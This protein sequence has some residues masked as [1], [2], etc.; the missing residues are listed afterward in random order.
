MT[1]IHY[2]Q[3]DNLVSK[4]KEVGALI[5]KDLIQNNGRVSYFANVL[6]YKVCDPEAWEYKRNE[7]YHYAEV[8][9]WKRNMVNWESRIEQAKYFPLHVI[10]ENTV[11]WESEKDVNEDPLEYM[12]KALPE[13]I[14]RYEAYVNNHFHNGGFFKNKEC[15]TKEGEKVYAVVP[16]VKSTLIGDAKNGFKRVTLPFV[17]E[18]NNSKFVYIYIEEKNINPHGEYISLSKEKAND[19]DS[20]EQLDSKKYMRV[21]ITSP[22]IEVYENGNEDASAPHKDKKPLHYSISSF[23]FAMRVNLARTVYSCERRNV[24]TI[25]TESLSNNSPEIDRNNEIEDNEVE[26]NL[27]TISHEEEVNTDIDDDLPFC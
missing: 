11:S 2:L 26:D 5:E 19:S 7:L 15:V 24:F 18:Q 21:D 4:L 10:N 23:N 8:G 17:D 16:H 22:I 9:N 3:T 20:E 6:D 14:I 13:D 1:A 12:S 25:N 27:S